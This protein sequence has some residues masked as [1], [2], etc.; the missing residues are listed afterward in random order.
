M[1][2]GASQG[3]QQPQ[4]PQQW[5]QSPMHGGQ[6]VCSHLFQPKNALYP[7]AVGKHICTCLLCL[8]L[9]HAS[10]GHAVSFDRKLLLRTLTLDKA[11]HAP[12][13]VERLLHVQT[14]QYYPQQ[15]V[16]QQY[17]PGN[18]QGVEQPWGQNGQPQ[19]QAPY[20]QGASM[21]A[22]SSPAN[23]QANPAWQPQQQQQGRRDVCG[24]RHV[25]HACR[26]GQP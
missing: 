25:K 12:A 8:W 4:G 10:C 26:P 2:Q 1:V 24:L 21:Y 17:G 14:P 3:Q 15:A 20:Q 9:C 6:P 11:E 23:G 18:P 19:Q 13:E 5:Q 16:P 22:S 7:R